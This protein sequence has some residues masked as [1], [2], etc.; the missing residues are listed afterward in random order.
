MTSIMHTGPG[1]ELLVSCPYLPQFPLHNLLHGEEKLYMV[2][3]S[4]NF[5]IEYQGEFEIL[6]VQDK[7]KHGI[8]IIR[9]NFYEVGDN[10][11]K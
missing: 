6:D 1:F 2:K 5:D 7:G 11:K 8:V 4:I 3:A 9:Q 10:N